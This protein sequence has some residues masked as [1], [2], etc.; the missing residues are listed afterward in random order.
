M[1]DRVATQELLASVDLVSLIEQEAPTRF[2]RAYGTGSKRTVKGECPWCGG[3]DR[4]AVFIADSPQRFKCGIHGNGCGRHGDAITFLREYKH[5]SFTQSIVFLQGDVNNLNIKPDDQNFRHPGLTYKDEKWQLRVERFCKQAEA[6]LWADPEGEVLSYL[7]QRGFEDETIKA[8]HLGSALYKGKLCLII[9][10][11]DIKKGIYTR[12]TLRDIRATDHKKRYTQ[13]ADGSNESLYGAVNLNRP[14]IL[15]EG[16]LDA[17]TI[18]QQLGDLA[19]QLAVV[20][21][22]STGANRTS[23]PLMRLSAAP[24]VF[25]AFDAEERGEQAAQY[26]LESLPHTTRWRTPIGKDANESYMQGVDIRAWIQAALSTLSEPE[27]PQTGEFTPQDARALVE[28]VFGPCEM[29]VFPAGTFTHDM[30]IV[31][32]QEQERV[33]ENA[34]RQRGKVLAG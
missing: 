15:V 13:L 5:L 19:E 8:A 21:T 28:S 29:R 7:W 23:K 11:Y 14:V 2:G 27:I 10:W 6:D 20:A 4:F 16:E 26:W 18:A 12:V 33:R 17:I 3:T 32:L 9:P 30:R 22:G 34:A 25:V 31:E 24:H 1:I